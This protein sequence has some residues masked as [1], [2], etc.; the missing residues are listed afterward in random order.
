MN[1]PPKDQKHR[2]R[3]REDLSLLPGPISPGGA[4][5]WTLHDPVRHAF[6]RI[7]RREFEILCLWGQPT[8][9]ILEKIN[10]QTTLQIAGSDVEKLQK[11]LARSE[12][13]RVGKE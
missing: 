7:G 11:F 1:P 3:L 4:P 10:Q 9:E 13:R 5:T 2:P 8:K 6:F 12:E